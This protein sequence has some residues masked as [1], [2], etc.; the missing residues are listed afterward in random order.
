MG[1]LLAYVFLPVIVIIIL[2]RIFRRTYKKPT[3]HRLFLLH[4]KGKIP[5]AQRGFCFV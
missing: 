4:A 1:V 2:D 3:T 5:A